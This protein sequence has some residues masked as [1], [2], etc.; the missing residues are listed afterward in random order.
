MTDITKTINDTLN[1]DAL[2]NA[3]D[4]AAF[5]ADSDMQFVRGGGYWADKLYW[6]VNYKDESVCYILL[7]DSSWTVWSDD[8]DYNS[9]EDFPL[10]EDM[11]EI[12]WKHLGICD[13]AERCFDGCARKRKVFFGKEFDNVC[14]TSMKFENPNAEM[15]EC[16]K[17]LMEIR[18]NSI[19]EVAQCQK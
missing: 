4:F 5:L 7:E 3:Q 16:L 2:Q 12:A 9:F 15:V 1:G 10:G 14:G 17:K 6:C 8:S 18:K 11:K 13:N 19:L